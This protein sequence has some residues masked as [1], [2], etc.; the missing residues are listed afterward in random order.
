MVTMNAFLNASR[1][2]KLFLLLIGDVYNRQESSVK[3]SSFF[4]F[5]EIVLILI[6]L[7]KI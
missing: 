6:K 1:T 7:D 5:L 2:I 3:K 4:P